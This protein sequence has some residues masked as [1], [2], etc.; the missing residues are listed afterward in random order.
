MLAPVP[1]QKRDRK[2]SAR[3]R[4]LEEE[5]RRAA[6]RQMITRVVLV[7]IVVLVLAAVATTLA[8]VPSSTTPASTTTT[9]TTAIQA[10]QAHANLLAEGAGC[11]ANPYTRVNTLHWRHPPKE[12][13]DPHYY[14]YATFDTT[15]G[16]FV[17][18]LD[19]KEAPVTVNSFRFLAIENYFNC[20]IFRTVI[21]GFKIQGGDPA[22][23]GAHG[24][25]YTI[26]DEYPSSAGHPT[27]PFETIVMANE[28]RP[29][30]GSDQFFI[31]VGA[32]GENLKPDYTAFGTV[33]SGLNVPYI[34]QDYG[35]K[36]GT[37]RVVERILKVTI[38]LTPPSSQ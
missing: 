9:T 38:S 10:A 20:T 17:V 34:I 2:R 19:T 1:T 26:P 5:V 25:G 29:G 30:T 12:V 7:A 11:P 6:R 35:S 4:K 32:A 36:S 16:T 15:A 27:Y 37:P 8:L 18:Q 31:V 28:G 13:V 3:A 23:D 21:P 14:Y 22:G 24:L 33:V